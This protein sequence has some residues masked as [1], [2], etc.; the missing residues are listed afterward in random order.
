MKRLLDVSRKS[1]TPSHTLKRYINICTSSLH[2]M[3]GVCVCV[4][5]C[6]T[7]TVRTTGLT[8]EAT[9][10][11]AVQRYS[12]CGYISRTETCRG[13]PSQLFNAHV[14]SG[15]HL[16]V[17]TIASA[18]VASTAFGFYFKYTHPDNPAPPCRQGT[19]LLEVYRT[20]IYVTGYVI[21][22]NHFTHR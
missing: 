19:G 12:T 20:W 16:R 5:L 15:P 11:C 17:V 18:F 1:K 8:T 22:A 9:I 3:R 21:S 6:Y 7:N 2:T 14:T 4:F 13:E 10:R